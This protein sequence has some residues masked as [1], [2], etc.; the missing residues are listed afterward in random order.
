MDKE[1]IEYIE[2]ELSKTI[3]ETEAKLRQAYRSVIDAAA[4]LEKLLN[5]RGQQGHE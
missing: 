4:A 1:E 5:M 3:S 2:N